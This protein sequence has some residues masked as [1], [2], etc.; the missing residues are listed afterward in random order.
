M[1]SLFIFL[2]DPF[3]KILSNT[4]HPHSFYCLVSLDECI[5]TKQ[6]QESFSP[7]FYQP[8]LSFGVGGEGGG[9]FWILP[10]YGKIWR[11]SFVENF[12]KLNPHPPFI[13]KGRGFIYVVTI[14]L[15]VDTNPVINVRWVRLSP[16][17]WPKLGH[18]EIK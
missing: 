8:L 18:G 4:F 3:F 12:R 13:K 16:P 15:R 1:T 10:F 17:Y 2:T 11:P 7:L 5:I 14:G 6:L 9:G